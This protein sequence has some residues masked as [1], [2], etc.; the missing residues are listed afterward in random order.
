MIRKEIGV[1]GKKG[2][3]NG[4]RDRDRDRDRETKASYRI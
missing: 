1:E 3:L 4:C 2:G